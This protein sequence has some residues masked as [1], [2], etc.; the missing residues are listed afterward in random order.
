MWKLALAMSTACMMSSA[1]LPQDIMP[2][3]AKIDSMSKHCVYNSAFYSQGSIICIG[4]RRALQCN[5][6]SWNTNPDPNN[7][8]NA[9]CKD[10]APA[11]PPR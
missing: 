5:I 3:P 1:A 2:D 6:G 10:Q 9:A 11:S 4:E 7:F 8:M